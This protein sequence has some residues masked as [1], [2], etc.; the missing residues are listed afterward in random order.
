LRAFFIARCSG[1]TV[2]YV[3]RVHS[4][5]TICGDLDHAAVGSA[6][7]VTKCHYSG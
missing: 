3:I 1:I 7:V 4:G 5:Y 2:G 6:A